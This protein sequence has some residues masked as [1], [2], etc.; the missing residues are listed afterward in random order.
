MQCKQKPRNRQNKKPAAGH[1]GHFY[2]G[3]N[4]TYSRFFIKFFIGVDALGYSLRNNAL[5]VIKKSM[6]NFITIIFM[7]VKILYIGSF[8]TSLSCCDENGL[9][10]VHSNLYGE[11]F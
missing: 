6:K 1:N 5:R 4:P 7:L 2:A 9:I 10:L 3:E 11:D 8:V